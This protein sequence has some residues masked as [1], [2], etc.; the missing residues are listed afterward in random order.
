MESGAVLCLG[1]K[2]I[3]LIGQCDLLIGCVTESTD[4]LFSI[5]SSFLFLIPY[6]ACVTVPSHSNDQ[7]IHFEGDDLS[8]E[9]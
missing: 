9:R 1:H 2:S 7:F 4:D 5:F 6:F 3:D 8:D